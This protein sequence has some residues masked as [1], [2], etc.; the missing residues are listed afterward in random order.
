MQV[1][2]KLVTEIK[3]N[4]VKNKKPEISLPPA[5]YY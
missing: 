4:I 3:I 5:F 2:D 1:T